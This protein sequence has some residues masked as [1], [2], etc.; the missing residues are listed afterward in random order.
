MAEEV[1]SQIKSICQSRGVLEP[2]VFTEFGSFTVGESGATIFQVIG[3]KLQNDRERWYMV[4]SSFM[5]DLIN[6]ALPGIEG[7][8][9]R[10]CG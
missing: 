4:D 7:T 8:S 10:E 2:N 6:G 3:T 9:D 1:I 5:N